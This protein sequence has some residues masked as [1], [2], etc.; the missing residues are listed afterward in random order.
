[1]PQT[2]QWRGQSA[3]RTSQSSSSHVSSHSSPLQPSVPESGMSAQPTEP[4]QQSKLRKRPK[5]SDL[6]HHQ[7]SPP[8][9]TS[10]TAFDRGRTLQRRCAS[11]D[12]VRRARTHFTSPDRY[13]SARSASIHDESQLRTGRAVGSLTPQERYAR[14]RD[15]RTSPFRRSSVSPSRIAASRRP[16]NS[17]TPLVPPT[18]TPSFVVA[19]DAL[20]RNV[21]VSTRTVTGRQVSIG[22][23]WNVGGA[24]AAQIPAHF[25]PRAAVR[26]GRGGLLASGTNAPMHVAHFLD[27]ETRDQAMRRHENRLAV[28]LDVDP[29]SRVLVNT[30]PDP[31]VDH[32]PLR[33][34]P[35]QHM[36]FIWSNNAWAELETP[37]PSPRVR[38]RPDP[39]RRVSSIPFRV[40]DAPRIRDD[41]YCSI[42]AYSYTC[43]ILAVAISHSVYIWSEVAGVQYPP[44]IPARLNNYVTS[45]SFSSTEGGHS[46]LAIGRQSGQVSLWSPLDVE[47]RFEARH[48][49]PVSCLAFKP[50]VSRRASTYFHT[51]SVA[52][53]DL[54]VGDDLG[55]VYYYSIEWP[56]STMKQFEPHWTGTMTV[57][58]KVS[59]HSQQICGLA[60]SPDDK[61]F[62]TGGNDNAAMLFQID[63]LLD[64][65]DETRGRELQRRPDRRDPII[66]SVTTSS[67]TPNRPINADLVRSWNRFSDDDAAEHI[68]L[69][70]I[71]RPRPTPQRTPP[72]PDAPAVFTPPIRQPGNTLPTPPTSPLRPSHIYTHV[73]HRHAPTPPRFSPSR[74]GPRSEQHIL[75]HPSGTQTRTFSH[76][77]AVKALAFA[78]WQPS[79]LATGGG[80][81]DR[82]IH[83]WHTETGCALAAINVFAQVTSLVW[84]TTKRELCATFGYAQPEHGVRVAVFDWPGCECVVSVNWE[85]RFPDEREVPRALCAVAYPGRPNGQGDG[86]VREG[87]EW[88]SRTVEEGCVIVAGSDES[89]RFH[90]VW[91]GERKGGKGGVG[92]G[93]GKG[94]LGGARVLEGFVEGIDGEVGGGRDV[95]R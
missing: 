66:T 83:F 62:A 80:S 72:S 82:Q 9:L 67:T 93:G 44:L 32:F 92:L 18:Y 79:L 5:I 95:I 90:E 65:D 81:N 1:M 6:Q 57:L 30:L 39:S 29:A 20:P 38:N 50:R 69:T 28:A 70:E 17:S 54:L 34:N 14:R 60:W 49:N 26:N 45:L 27:I 42:L 48:P 23:V 87:Q 13:V 73:R 78:P 59:A 85:S 94:V 35:A 8:V 16:A 36:P 91:A 75:T 86:G 76:T 31:F 77:A 2:T 43:G 84:S 63:K 11:A 25:G 3:R 41:Y 46:I 47:M 10:A 4:L 24:A 55:D 68:N 33:D 89:I 56:D 37:P 58:A 15:V 74:Y 51:Y 52:C 7:S 88:A 64:S 12:S 53:E 61:Y 19:N 40:L 71:L 22:A 21:D